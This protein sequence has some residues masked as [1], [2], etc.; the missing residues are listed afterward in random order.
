MDELIPLVYNE[1]RALAAALVHQNGWDGSIAPTALVH[2]AYLKLVGES[3]EWKDRAHFFNVAAMAMRQLLADHARRHRARKRG[4]EGWTRVTL[5]GISAAKTRQ[6]VDLTAL[7]AALSKLNALN[8]RQ[9]RVVELRFLAGLSV[10]ETAEA[11]G[12]SDRTIEMDW[13]FSRAWLRRELGAAGA[14]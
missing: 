1:L 8:Q 2:E 13:R 12:V 4:G 6:D 10:G 7:D 3:G 14:G 5:S 9:A 11:L